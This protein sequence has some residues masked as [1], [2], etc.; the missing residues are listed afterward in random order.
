[1]CYRPTNDGGRALPPA[2]LPLPMPACLAAWWDSGFRFRIPIP[3]S[4]FPDSRWDSG[5]GFGKKEMKKQKTERTEMLAGTVGIG[6]PWV[7]VCT[8]VFSLLVCQM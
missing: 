3:D 4:G 8:I 5:R 7:S 2:C 1:M 6:Y